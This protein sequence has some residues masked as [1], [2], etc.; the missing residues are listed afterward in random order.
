MLMFHINIVLTYILCVCYFWQCWM[1][2]FIMCADRC[3]HSVYQLCCFDQYYVI[4]G[5]F[6]PTCVPFFVLQFLTLVL[7]SVGHV[8]TM[9]SVGG[10]V[11]TIIFVMWVLFH[12]LFCR[13][14]F[15]Q[16]VLWVL[17]SQF[18]MWILFSQCVL[19]VFFSQGVLL[20]V[21][22]SQFVVT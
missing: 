14:C 22:V 19:W 9:C 16:S 4:A 5:V 15:S 18:V 2:F 10:L 20:V 12:N 17:L 7:F 13:Y 1:C 3:S 6:W 11:F 21:L 8:F